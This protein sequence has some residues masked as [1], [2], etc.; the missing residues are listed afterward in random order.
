M[1]KSIDK[2]SRQSENHSGLSVIPWKN[3]T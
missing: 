3:A 2:I 1:T